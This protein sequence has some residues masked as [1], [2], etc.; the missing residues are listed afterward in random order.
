M[1][2]TF[3]HFLNFKNKS[4]PGL[5]QISE[6]V[7]F[8][9]ATF[10]VE[11]GANRY[12]RDIRYGNEE[13]SLIFW[14]GEFEPSKDYTQY[15][16]GTLIY[17]LTH[18]FEYLIEWDK[19]FGFESEVEYILKRNGQ[20]FTI[21]VLDYQLRRTDGKTYFEC[22]VVQQTTLSLVN[23]LADTKIDVFSNK[24]IDE[25]IIA[26]IATENILL[27]AKPKVG[28]SS[29]TSRNTTALATGADLLVFAN[30]GAEL[31]VDQTRF[32]VGANN[33]SHSVLY[34]IKK[35][36]SWI[37]NADALN[38]DTLVPYDYQQFCYVF[39]ED[40][41]TNVNIEITNLEAFTSQ[42]IINN[43]FATVTSGSGR[44]RLVA[45]LAFQN[46]L[47]N[48]VKYELYRKDF[49]FVPETPIE[50][51]PNS[52]NL[53]LPLI[54][55]G[56]RL[57]IYL[58]P[59]TEAEIDFNETDLSSNLTGY[60]VRSRMRN[61]EVKITSTATGIDSVIKGVRYVDLFKQWAK[62]VVKKPIEAA[63]FD[64]G[65]EFYDQFAFNA[66]MI[67]QFTD[68]PY[69]VTFKDL[70]NG[71]QEVN[72]DYQVTQ[73]SIQIKS[74]EDFYANVEIGAFTQAPST[75][76]SEIYNEEYAIVN[77]EFA[78]GTSESS[79]SENNTID[80]IHTESQ[81][82]TPNKQVEGVK[83]VDVKHIRDPFVGESAR[84]KGITTKPDT[85]L[86]N[87]DKTF[88]YDIVP[89]APNTKLE[90]NFFVTHNYSNGILQLLNDNTFN[91]GL[92][93]F[94]E[95]NTIE[96]KGT[97]N[98]GTYTVIRFEQSVITLQPIIATLNYNG[99]LSTIIEYPLT[100][101]L[102]TNR[103]NEGFTLIEN[104]TAG[105]NFGNLLYTISRNKERWGQWIA[106]ACRYKPLG[107]IKNT[108]FKTNGLAR[109]RF[110]S[111]RIYQENE[112][113]A[114]SDLQ[115]PFLEPRIVTTK[116][117]AEFDEVLQMLKDLGQKN[118]YIRVVNLLGDVVK[119]HPKKLTYEWSTRLMTIDGEP[120][121]LDD[122][123]V[124]T[125]VGSEMFIDGIVID[126]FKTDNEYFM[127]YDIN[128][129][130]LISPTNY[131]K[132]SINGNTYTNVV[133]FVA[134]LENI[135]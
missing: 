107:L 119:L 40:E 9:G 89:L 2:Q 134:A 79:E 27:K 46:D 96:I 75:E 123:I 34:G 130:S 29:W 36:E 120:R 105:Y 60:Y 8:D 87:D 126:W 53:F 110:G 125:S 61:M 47:D 95:G 83:K 58:E 77:F 68:K 30:D 16:D 70:F 112:N 50:Y 94:S 67:R 90:K 62:S 44:V 7:K 133:D 114:V 99:L 80:A 85:A 14:K 74:Y 86:Q 117:F 25:N 42:E 19:E 12:G 100:N 39:S 84:A 6:P 32:S 128:N 72:A 104:I 121:I 73:E 18:G 106:T 55:R 43:S 97:R 45:M 131:Q 127:A 108:F 17:Y 51:L 124:I 22:K 35:S 93:G 64:V 91:W 118:G 37:Y 109:S 69:Y 92:L 54:S 102:Y 38:P 4:F 13:I 1:A 20:Q 28:V 5:I 66:L 11:Q 129:V 21:G 78:Y 48:G 56:Q 76:Y 26:P 122:I 116:F 111:G 103:T 98:A 23:R 71:V 24:D 52:F 33:A 135:V 88:V 113:R 101:V 15:P 49:F 31:I 10:T 65:G 63:R 115:K 81:D 82:L 57:Y 3:E 59:S 41:N 132:V